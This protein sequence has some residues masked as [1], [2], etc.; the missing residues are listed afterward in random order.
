MPDTEVLIAGAG[1]TGLI[2]ALWLKRLGAR[3]RIIDKEALPGTTSRALVVHARTLELYRQAGL[4][5]AVVEN[6][7][8]FDAVNMWVRAKQVARVVFGEMG[9][10]LSPYPYALIFPQ[11][12]HERFLI[13]RLRELGVEVERPL[14]L[15]SFDDRGDRVIARM[16]RPDGS[17]ESCEAA[18]LAGCDGAHSV[19]RAALGTG[20]PGGTYEHLFYVADAQATGPVVNQELHVAL[21]EADILG[22]FPMKGEDRVRL[23]GTVRQDA[24]HS[25][26][27]WN[28]VSRAVIEHLGIDVKKLNWFSTYHVHHRVASN[29]RVGRA[30]LLGDAAHIHSPVGGQGMNTGLGDGINL[31]WKLAAVLRQR[32]NARILDTYEPERVAFAKRLVAT[33]DRA[34]QVVTSTGRLA[35]FVR[36][37]VVPLVLPPIFATSIMRRFMF[38]T[39]SQ[40]GI[41]YR[42]SALSSGAAGDVKAGD[43]LPWLALDGAGDP[44]AADNFA[45]LVSMDW[46]VHVYGAP[47]PAIAQ[48]CRARRFALHSFEWRDAMQAA[49]F[50]AN[51]AYLIRPDGYV[52]FADVAAGAEKL[53]AYVEAWQL[54][55]RIASA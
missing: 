41:N 13:E 33:T 48:F 53:Q 19:V 42:D 49:G 12:Q 37:H 29:F 38:R 43:R 17:E 27:E 30:F 31:A 44:S 7:V 14:Q 18:Y 5:D 34:F 45:P 28:D 55:G 9:I 46:Q 22:A 2:L 35:A 11:D 25:T 39:I 21:D 36:L 24:D 40:T 4:A 23:I 20:F 10:G 54:K 50:V 15:H 6:G 32:A 47:S 51:A 52:G 8:R 3:V 26:L 1:P 16:R